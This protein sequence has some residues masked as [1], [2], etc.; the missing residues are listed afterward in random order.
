MIDKRHKIVKA[1]AGGVV[2]IREEWSKNPKFV[3]FDE[4]I[5]KLLR[6]VFTIFFQFILLYISVIILI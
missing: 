1:S 3:N 2:K 4:L 6:Y 5:T